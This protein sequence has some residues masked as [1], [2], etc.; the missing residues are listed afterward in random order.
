L[1]NC[2]ETGAF[3]GEGV[4]AESVRGPGILGLDWFYKM[5]KVIVEEVI[6]GWRTQLTYWWEWKSKLSMPPRSG[7]SASRLG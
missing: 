5:C 7:I 4:A 2:D 1:G 6:E 3:F